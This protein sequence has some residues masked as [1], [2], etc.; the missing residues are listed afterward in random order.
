M[1]PNKGNYFSPQNK[2]VKAPLNK[3]IKEEITPTLT[4]KHIT[5]TLSDG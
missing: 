5:K 4:T 2:R 1:C 3:L